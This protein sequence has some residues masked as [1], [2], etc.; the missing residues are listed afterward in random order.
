MFNQDYERRALHCAHGWAQFDGALVMDKWKKTIRR[1]VGTLAAVFGAIVLGWL[2]HV[3]DRYAEF[4]DQ[5]ELLWPIVELL[6]LVDLIEDWCKDVSMITA[7]SFVYAGALFTWLAPPVMLAGLLN[8]AKP[9]LELPILVILLLPI[10]VLF[11]AANAAGLLLVVYYFCFC[12][13]LALPYFLGYGT[14][15]LGMYLRVDRRPKC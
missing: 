13:L 4:I 6:G 7:M 14:R 11:L 12:W 8:R 5:G 10:F 1:H 15:K 3:W 9:W 2:A